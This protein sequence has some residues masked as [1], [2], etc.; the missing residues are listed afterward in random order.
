[1]ARLYIAHGT[2]LHCSPCFPIS[3]FAKILHGIEV[4]ATPPERC[5]RG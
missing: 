3:L 5:D 4:I 1:M 2:S